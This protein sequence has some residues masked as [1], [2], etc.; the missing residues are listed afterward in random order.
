MGDLAL[1]LRIAGLSM[2]VLAL[3]HVPMTRHFRWR[4]DAAKLTPLNRQIFHVHCFFVCLAVAMMGML[5][6]ASPET[7][8]E[9]SRLAMQVSGG[10]ALF[11]LIRLVV[12]F[13]VYE[14]AHW[15]GKGLETAAH[16]FFAGLWAYYVAI[17]G[18]VWW[19]QLQ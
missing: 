2:I 6:L 11:W 17:F 3:A 16:I 12:Q 15:R 9:R 19:R 7:L 8:L 5:A 1:H 13:F 10:I 14:R 4:E 18:A